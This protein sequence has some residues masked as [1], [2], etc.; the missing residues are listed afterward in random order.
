MALTALNYQGF[1]NLEDAELTFSPDFNFIT[2]DNGAGKTNLLEAI[3]FVGLA[4]SFRLKEE[5]N[6]IQEN[7]K[8]LRVSAQANGHNASIFLDTTTKKITL[9]GNEIRRLSEY[10]GWLGIT[11]LSIEDMWIVR[12]SPRMR[13]AFLDWGIAKTSSSYLANMMEYR[14]ILRQ[15]NRL[16]QSAAENGNPAVLEVFDEQLIKVGNEI[17]RAREKNLPL[18]EECIA[19]LGG[20]FGLKSLGIRYQSSCP[21]MELTNQILADVR[22]KELVFG[23]T[24]VGPHR[25]DLL[26]SINGHLLRTYASEGEERAAVLTLKLAESEIL[27]RK[28]GERPLLLLDEAAAELDHHKREILLEL[29][30]GQVFFA[31][32]QPPQKRVFPGK[33]CKFF[34]VERGI[35]EV[36]P[37]H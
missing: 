24:I 4:S 1:R 15:R 16:L 30:K 36:S 9:Q 28:K 7:A 3:F 25:D 13:R 11:L 5:K 33:D 18:L 21:N 32:T 34:T 8:Y 17:Y 31:S 10:I 29:L 27:Y 14:R 26:F 20:N 6:L 19:D 35:F 37:A 22:S 12:G 23:R 2:G